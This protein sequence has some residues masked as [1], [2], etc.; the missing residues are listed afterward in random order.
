MINL[1]Q[2]KHAF[3]LAE[4]IIVCSLFAVMVIWII[5]AINRS[6]VYLDNTR[7][8]VRATNLAREWVEMVYNRRDTNRRKYSWN[9][10]AH[11]LD[12]GTW[13]SLWVWTYVIKEWEENGDKFIYLERLDDISDPTIKPYEIEGFFSSAYSTQREASEIIFTGNYSYY[14]WWTLHTWWKVTDL[15]AVSWLK[16]YRIVRVYGVY[17]KNVDSPD[18]WIGGPSYNYSAKSWEPEEMRF[19]VKVFYTASLWW[20]HAVELCSIMT[21][22]QE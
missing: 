13:G 1:K 16:F 11:R 6:F 5:F 19:C 17:K 7:L 9:K 4:V 18:S 22:F 14:S 12:T 2:K 20:Q 21:N 8:S 3:T 10:D 15:L